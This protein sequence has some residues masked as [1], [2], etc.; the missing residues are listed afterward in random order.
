MDP[1]C[2]AWL[3]RVQVELAGAAA[4]GTH[5]YRTAAGSKVVLPLKLPLGDWAVQ[6]TPAAQYNRMQ[7]LFRSSI[8]TPSRQNRAAL[9]LRYDVSF[10]RSIGAVPSRYSVSDDGSFT[11]DTTDHF[12]LAA[13]GDTQGL[14]ALIDS[15]PELLDSQDESGDS[16]LYKAARS[17]FCDMVE[18]LIAKGADVNIVKHMGSSSLH[19]A[20]YFGHEIVTASLLA[21]NCDRSLKNKYGST[22]LDEA[23][24]PAIRYLLM[25]DVETV[26]KQLVVSG[27]GA[28]LRPVIHEGEVIAW[29][30]DRQLQLI[31]DSLGDG[32]S[33]IPADWRVSWHGTKA[34]NLESIMRHNLQAAGSGNA[35]AQGMPQDNHISLGETLFG[36]DN[37]AG[38]IFLS[39]S[40]AYA[41]HPC[42]AGRL[43]GGGAEYIVLVDARVRP[44]S[45]K[46]FASTTGSSFL[47]LG[48]DAE[49]EAEL[50][51]HP[52]QFGHP[53]IRGKE[54]NGDDSINTIL[55][56][57]STAGKTN[58]VVTGVVLL[59]RQ[60]LSETGL[61]NA[62]LSSI[63]TGENVPNPS[64]SS[65][66]QKDSN[67]GLELLQDVKDL[68]ALW[69]KN[70]E[71]EASKKLQYCMEQH[72]PSPNMFKLIPPEDIKDLVLS[73]DQDF[74]VKAVE[75]AEELLEEIDCNVAKPDSVRLGDRRGRLAEVQPVV[76][77]HTIREPATNTPL[78]HSA[79]LK[80]LAWKLVRNIGSRNIALSGL[81]YGDMY[82]VEEQFLHLL[83]KKE[84]EKGME[85]GFVMC[86]PGRD[87]RKVAM[88]LIRECKVP[89]LFLDVTTEPSV[90]FDARSISE[91]GDEILDALKE[92]DGLFT[93]L[94]YPKP[95]IAGRGFEGQEAPMGQVYVN[96][97]DLMECVDLQSTGD[98]SSSD[99]NFENYAKDH[100]NVRALEEMFSKIQKMDHKNRITG[101]LF[102]EGRGRGLHTDYACMAAWLRK[103]F[104]APQY[105][106]L[107][108]A[109]GGSGTEQASSLDAVEA[110]AD[111]IWAGFIPQAAQ[112][113]HNSYFLFLDNLMTNGNEKV[114]PQ[115]D[116]H[117]GVEVA[118][119]LYTL[120][121]NSVCY[122]DDCPIWGRNAEPLVH[123]AFSITNADEW[124]SKT[125]TMYHIWSDEQKV[126]MGGNRRTLADLEQK[127][128]RKEKFDNYRQ[129]RIAP[130]VTDE[131]N[132]GDRMGELKLVKRGGRPAQE[133]KKHTG[134]LA[135][136]IMLATMNAGLRV[137]YDSPGMLKKVASWVQHCS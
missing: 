50:P 63:L 88:R 48:E 68:R 105:K 91:V 28:C 114:W 37:F 26:L 27:V 67:M 62:A 82:T 93:H 86:G 100:E 16:L 71:E 22:A 56:V 87:D 117:T 43:F 119:M 101:I 135:R 113:G 58:V 102:E 134:R 9:S 76:M 133:A 79:E 74:Y 78:G 29:R 125:G 109:H 64:P 34:D 57:D 17:G 121:F 54:A 69:T 99:R 72:Y 41:S 126:S 123:T 73:P 80:Y 65:S 129:Y 131:S 84:G 40:I 39:P 132:I 136:Q 10:R 107:L 19:A 18:A 61:S 55:R 12:T 44:G 111:G 94:G 8:R 33:H 23:C 120:N 25:A 35:G 104:E 52:D 85:G 60:F 3:E 90:R 21:R 122:P 89:N 2:S 13:I 24:T 32:T 128:D 1:E 118:K 97:V 45:Y 127:I 106:I 53:E 49:L 15:S 137:N 7:P 98:W 5:Q 20:A 14:I 6:T 115:F 30:V 66:S 36:I 4:R 46:T 11:Y 112:A 83:Y 81:Y 92:A 47:S 124:R 116:L 38:A 51:G 108:H 96:F 31:K 130:L 70:N 103:H 59:K 77:D 95:T 110:G 42:F 75:Q